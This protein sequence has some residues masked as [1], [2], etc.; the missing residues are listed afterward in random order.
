MNLDKIIEN[1]LKS[2]KDD[3]CH[4][5][6]E[7]SSYYIFNNDCRE[8]L[9]KIPDNNIDFIVTDP[10]Y[11][12]DGMDNNWND[13][14]L[15]RRSKYSNVIVGIPA[16]MKFD[17]KQG[18]NLQ[19]FL[20]PICQDFFRILKPGGFCIIFS[21]GRLYHRTA[22][23]LDLA[24]FEIRDLMAWKY[25]GQAKAFS[26]DHFIKKDKNKTEEE[27]EKLIAELKGLKTPQLKPQMEPMVLAQKPREGTF[28]ENWEKYQVG[29]M[30]T[31][32]SLDGKF[33]GTVM[34][35]SKKIRKN[36]T[37]EKIEHMTVKPVHLISHL[38]RLFTR[39]GQTVL[40][41]FVGS[42]SHA[43]AAL[44]NNRNFIGYEIEK[45]YFDIAKNRLEKEVSQKSLF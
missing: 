15:K 32:E 17:R 28:V 30:N 36:E 43:L 38:I 4:K 1:S 14:E 26:Q 42:G 45:K 44:M 12:I 25:E 22:M 27:K 16:G 41:P 19:K 39:E 35:V 6:N 10:P 7:D 23:A 34:E 40:D 3:Y 31:N 11:F 37:D 21:Q 13:G 20:E 33:P 2:N 18:E 24:G 5:N 29:L 9:K 8:G